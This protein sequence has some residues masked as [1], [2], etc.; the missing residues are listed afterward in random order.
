MNF[1]DEMFYHRF[2]IVG[3][4]FYSI[5]LSLPIFKNERVRLAVSVLHLGVSGQGKPNNNKRRK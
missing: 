1:S 4:S 5:D 2:G 3:T